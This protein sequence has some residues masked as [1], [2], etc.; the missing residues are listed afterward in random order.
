MIRGIVLKL[1]LLTTALCLLIVAL[2]FAGQTVFFKQF[3]VHQKVEEVK[4]AVHTFQQDYMKTNGEPKAVAELEQEFYREHGTW[5]AMLEEWGVCCIPAILRWRSD[6][7]RR[8]A[9]RRLPAKR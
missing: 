2:I 8:T 7:N 1:F 9:S 5:I 4:A 3:Y 6:W